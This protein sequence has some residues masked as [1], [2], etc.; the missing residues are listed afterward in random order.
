VVDRV[1]E[2]ILDEAVDFGADLIVLGK[3]RRGEFAARVLGSVTTRVVRRSRC[4]VIVAPRTPGG[5][6]QPVAQSSA[7]GH[8]S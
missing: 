6:R 3:P 1:A 4:P 8:R 2:A 7:P 5:R